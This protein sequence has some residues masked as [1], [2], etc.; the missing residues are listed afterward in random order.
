MHKK[1]YYRGGEFLP[2][3]WMS[4][5]GLMDQK[6]SSKSDVWS[7]GV[8]VWEILNL[9]EYVC[10][11]YA[12]RLWNSFCIG[13]ATVPMKLSYQNFFSDKTTSQV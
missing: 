1:S 4:P 3:R 10:L 13:E 6:F 8:L 7:F 5:E 11:Y 2:I 12:Q 9:G